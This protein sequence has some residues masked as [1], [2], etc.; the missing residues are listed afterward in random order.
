MRPWDFYAYVGIFTLSMIGVWSFYIL[1]KDFL[2]VRIGWTRLGELG[3]WRAI[4][5]AIW[6]PQ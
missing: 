5:A 2:V 6:R 1:V 3:F 4:P